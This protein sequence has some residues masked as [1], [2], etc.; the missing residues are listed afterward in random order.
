MPLELRIWVRRLALA[1]AG[2]AASA[3]PAAAQCVMC[4][5]TASAQ[6]AEGIRALNFGILVLLIPPLAILSG[7]LLYAF[8]YRNTDPAWDYS[9]QEPLE[10]LR[11]DP[12]QRPDPGQSLPLPQREMA[13]SDR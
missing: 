10:A 8:R 2:V 13:P 11:E 6:R 1:A 3:L 5:T 7:L 12:W 9:R 4:W